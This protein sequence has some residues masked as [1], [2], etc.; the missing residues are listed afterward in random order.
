MKSLW[1]EGENFDVSP[2]LNVSRHLNDKE[3]KVIM[4]QVNIK[5]ELL[6]QLRPY[7]FS[8][9]YVR[10]VYMILMKMIYSFTVNL[11]SNIF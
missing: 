6:M 2:D 11:L 8:V 1:L 9:I 7:K 3:K 10:N 5:T 4:K